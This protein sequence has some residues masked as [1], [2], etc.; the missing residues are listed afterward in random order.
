MLNMQTQPHPG[1]WLIQVESKP[2]T[3]EEKKLEK[4]RK[5]YGKVCRD[6]FTAC[7]TVRTL[8]F[9]MDRFRR[10]YWHLPPLRGVIIESLESSLNDLTSC[11]TDLSLKLEDPYLPSPTENQSTKQSNHSTEQHLTEIK[12]ETKPDMTSENMDTEPTNFSTP[13]I[14]KTEAEK[15]DLIKS[16]PKLELPDTL[17][18][19]V[20]NG[21]SI[22][23]PLL[24]KN[25]TTTTG[26]LGDA[27]QSVASWLN[28]TIDNIFGAS[29]AP[30]S[31][32]RASVDSASLLSSSRINSQTDL[33]QSAS[34]S[35]DQ[36]KPIQSTSSLVLPP[37]SQ[38]TNGLVQPQAT[39]S[40]ADDTWFD[41]NR[42]VHNTSFLLSFLLEAQG[43][44]Y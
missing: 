2:S 35:P 31:S 10:L 38:S 12:S 22:T 33:G 21:Y 9:G 34:Q 41:L 5:Q 19:Q 15:L 18:S 28:S 43:L 7:N 23:P 39:V 29:V 26:T 40:E 20:V 1:F 44:L 3:A 30:P 42:F 6:V 11:P 32:G 16:C 25:A 37:F 13:L 27:S 36:P 14:C 24:A 17:S 8:P 4:L